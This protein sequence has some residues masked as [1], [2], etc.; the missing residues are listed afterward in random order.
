MASG[1]TL[2]NA[3]RVLIQKAGKAPPRVTGEAMPVVP[4]QLD[5][6][7][8]AP[9]AVPRSRLPEGP[10]AAARTQKPNATYNP[11]TQ[12]NE[13]FDGATD[14]SIMGVAEPR[15]NAY[16]RAG[17]VEVEADEIA[18]GTVHR[19]ESISTKGNKEV[20]PDQ[21]MSLQNILEDEI[22]QGTANRAKKGPAG[23]KGPL[24]AGLRNPDRSGIDFE[25]ERHTSEV[26]RI[27]ALKDEGKNDIASEVTNSVKSGE[28]NAEI[29]DVMNLFKAKSGERGM[30]NITALEKAPLN[31]TTALKQA[32][33]AGDQKAIDEIAKIKV[34]S[35]LWDQWSGLGKAA[36]AARNGD[37]AAL[38]KIRQMGRWLTKGN[39]IE[40]LEMF[41]KGQVSGRAATAAERK[42]TQGLGDTRGQNQELPANA[43]GQFDEAG[44]PINEMIDPGPAPD[45]NAQFSGNEWDLMRRRAAEGIPMDGK[46]FEN[47]ATQ[48]LIDQLLSKETPFKGGRQAPPVEGTLSTED[49]LL[50]ILRDIQQGNLGAIG[51]PSP[52]PKQ[53]GGPFDKLMQPFRP[54]QPY[55]TI[56][57][58]LDALFEVDPKSAKAVLDRFVKEAETVNQGTHFDDIL[59]NF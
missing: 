46:R 19:D 2:V 7:G 13:G 42:A 15:Y 44:D 21:D 58:Q 32:A 28:I 27:R 14:N 37:E 3:L 40:Q 57:A 20:L 54:G 26:E 12:T 25:G 31:P 9:R 56:E 5:L 1:N 8:M 49:T 16:E 10:G 6:P 29:Q 59:D 23:K 55:E 50:N 24:E 36:K 35:Q 41:P 22:V 4:G 34:S 17:R 48:G 33:A 38:N 52:M 30:F 45:A 47:P 18:P 43:Q 11:A 53:V 51:A 39:P